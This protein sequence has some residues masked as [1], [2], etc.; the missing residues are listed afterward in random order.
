MNKIRALALDLDGTVYRGN[1]AVE[2]ARDAISTLINLNYQVFYFTNNSGKNRQQIVNKLNRLG[3]PAKPQNTY[4]TSY[5]IS[6]YLLQKKLKN[7]YV[8]GTYGL[9]RELLSCGIKIKD[10]STVCAVVVGLDPYF[11]YD[12]ITMALEAINNG[13]KLIVA[14]SD[15]SYPVEGNRRLPGCGAMVAAITAATLHEPDFSVGKPNTYMLDLLCKEHKLSPKEICIVGDSPES[16]MKM[17][18]NLKCT[19]I[20]FDPKNMFRSFSGNKVKGHSEII[21]LINQK[22]ER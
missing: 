9:K 17:A 6:K 19:S 4:T 20:L 1:S 16:D 10:S 21:S 13:A 2:G 15:P 14:N 8:I 5:A 22:R 7:I 3:F 11:D 12:K 18:N